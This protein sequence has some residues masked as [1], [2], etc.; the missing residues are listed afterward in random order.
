M[1]YF[2][3]LETY[4]S[5]KE[6]ELFCLQEV[7]STN[8]FLKKKAGDHKML[9]VALR[10]TAGRGRLG[11]AWN[12]QGENVYAS[13]YYPALQQ[14]TDALTLCVAL[15]VSDALKE[16]GAK[17]QI[18]WP[19]DIYL[20]GKKLCGILC[21]GIYQGARLGGFVIG[22]GVNVNQD[23]FEGEIAQS[24]AS[25]RQALGHE[26]PLAQV[27]CRIYD[28]LELWM[29]RFFAEGFAPFREEYIRRSYLQG[30]EVVAGKQ[31]GICIGVSP[32]GELLLRAGEVVQSVRFGEAL[33]RVRPIA[34]EAGKEKAR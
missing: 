6:L 20:E 10:Q 25:L 29:A 33:Q 3:Q 8:T 12:S 1:S 26:V 17:A 15:A 11:R 32:K 34:H 22:I 7:D 30:K 13:F 14:Q 9:A 4:F 21:E 24:A 28:C 2:E 31:T 23:T 19:N 5:K 18:K 27:V 16:L